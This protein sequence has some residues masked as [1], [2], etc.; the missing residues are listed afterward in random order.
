MPAERH[1]LMATADNDRLYVFG[2]AEGLSWTPTN[3]VWQYTPATDQWQALPPMPET[4]LA[5]AAVRLA[6]KIYVAGGAGGSEA[7]LEFWPAQETWQLLPGP[8]QP[9][10]HVNAVAF[11]DELWVL[12]GR[13]PGVGELATV[14]IYNPTNNTW[15]AGPAM[16]VARAGFAA[17]V[18]QAIAGEYI[19]VAGGEVIF[20]GTET[21][22]SVEILAAG[23]PNWSFGPRLPIPIHGVGGA[24][25]EF[26][27]SFLLLGGSL[28]A[29]A[30]E[31]EGQVQIYEP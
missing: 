3:T 12:G 28:R 6:D 18:G 22:D 30:I 19:I 24:A 16:N 13:W 20:N 23:S 29:G 21:L 10:E 4:R 5:G 8:D 11:Q 15:R 1:H 17:A 31:N 9:R 14:E 2:G 26:K 25:L 7:L 27:G